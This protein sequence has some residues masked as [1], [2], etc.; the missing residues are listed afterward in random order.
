MRLLWSINVADYARKALR[1]YF[2]SSDMYD[3]AFELS[4]E[5]RTQP[6]LLLY[7]YCTCFFLLLLANFQIPLS[8]LNEI[9]ELGAL[10]MSWLPSSLLTFLL[11]KPLCCFLQTLYTYCHILHCTSCMSNLW[12]CWFVCPSA[13]SGVMG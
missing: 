1:F 12:A 3:H 11:L 10:L 13:I 7:L 8:I 4:S 2:L 6:C 9:A 5:L